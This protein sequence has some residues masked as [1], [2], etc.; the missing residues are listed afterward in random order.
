M[1]TRSKNESEMPVS[2][3]VSVWFAELCFEA[4]RNERCNTHLVNLRS[5]NSITVHR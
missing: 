4:A 3:L 5:I 1:K 2:V